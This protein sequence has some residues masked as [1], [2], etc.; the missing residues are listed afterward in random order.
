MQP[1]QLTNLP[2]KC[3]HLKLIFSPD[4]FKGSLTSLEAAQAMK[5]GAQRVFPKAET[6][7][8]PLADGGEGTLDALLSDSGFRRNARVQSPLG[9]E[10]LADWGKLPDGRGL[11]EMAQASGLALVPENARDALAASSFGTGQLIKAALDAGCHELLIGIG[12]SATTDGGSG[13]LSALGARFLDVHGKVLPPGGGALQELHNIDLSGL[14]PR[15]PS[16]L[17]TV[18][19]D[20]DNPLLGGEGTAFIYAPQ[21]GA[22]YDEVQMLDAALGRLAQVSAHTLGRDLSGLPGAG[23]AGGVGFGLLAFCGARVRSGIEVVLKARRFSE[24]LQGAALVLTGEGALDKQTLS[25]KTIAG[26]C[27]EAKKQKVP[28]IAFGGKVALS[29]QEMDALGLVTAFS[30][31][32][33]PLL[34]KECLVRADELLADSVERALRFFAL[35]EDGAMRLDD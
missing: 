35:C 32:H 3:S 22:S 18:L 8:V 2:W 34:L 26:V 11:I 25:G 15:L 29:G 17:I 7:L 5:R 28:V 14:D 16:T 23:A 10:I 19:S 6:V 4:S 27:W 12:G 24:K 13:M 30:I 33:A 20:V 21:K 9:E 1:A 31:A